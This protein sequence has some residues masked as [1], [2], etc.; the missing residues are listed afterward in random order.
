MQKFSQLNVQEIS[1][2]YAKKYVRLVAAAVAGAMS[3]Q[4]K[5]FFVITS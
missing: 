1:L 2:S 4:R 5:V 3:K